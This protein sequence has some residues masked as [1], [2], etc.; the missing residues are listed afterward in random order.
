M[1][2][3]ATPTLT[4]E[5]ALAAPYLPGFQP[6]ETVIVRAWLEQDASAYDAFAFDVRIGQGVTPPEDAPEYAKRF[7]R[8]TTQKRIDVVAFAGR[9]VSLW[10]VKIQ[11]NLGA[12][13]QMLGYCHLWEVQF[14]AWPVDQC[15]ILCHLIN[16]DTA[17]V[18]GRH[19]MPFYV[20]PDIVLPPLRTLSPS[21]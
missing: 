13:G 21:E 17:A 1:D 20:F 18:F 9:R 11:A 4:R 15:G 3:P 19:K 10:E 14:P 7:V 8:K 5:Q 2:Y 6:G 16:L 12:L